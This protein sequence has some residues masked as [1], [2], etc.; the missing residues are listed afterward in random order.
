MGNK[1]KNLI[2][3][4]PYIFQTVYFNFHHL[5]FKQAIFLPI[6][7]YKPQLV[8]TK[9]KIIIDGG[10]FP[11][12]IKLGLHG[13]S[14]YKNNGIMI[15]NNGCIV[16]KGQCNIGSGAKLSVGKGAVLTFSDYFS[17]T[18]EMKIVCSNRITF[19]RNVLIGWECIFMD[20]N[21]HELMT[22]DGKPYGNVSEPIRIGNKCWFAFRNVIM[23]GTIVPDGCVVASNS[24][25][26]K[27]YSPHVYS[28]IAG[29]P[30]Q[31]KREGITINP[32]SK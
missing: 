17:S 15:Q 5:P 30:A 10:A 1:I 27:D 8:S 14:I 4:V 6:I 2:K 18:A 7:L 19:G 12:M 3:A 20:T 24:L 25:L 13:V 22:I 11:G 29:S 16:F 26:N 23:P 32:N 9:G 21:F 28:L 31:I